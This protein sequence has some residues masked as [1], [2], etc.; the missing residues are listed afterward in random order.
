[1]DDNQSRKSILII[2]CFVLLVAFSA[3]L[4]TP[5]AFSQHA[6]S[7]KAYATQEQ[8]DE[9]TYLFDGQKYVQPDMSWADK[10][11]E[12]MNATPMDKLAGFARK[13]WAGIAVVCVAIAVGIGIGIG[14][15]VSGKH[16]DNEE[17]HV[18]PD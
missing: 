16:A 11:W 5:I 6:A 14:K 18:K 15:S 4:V 7:N 10:A 2:A 3:C 17:S 9:E 8:E 1:M 13:N 12:E